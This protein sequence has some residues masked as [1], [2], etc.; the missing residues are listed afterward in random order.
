MKIFITLLFIV[1][2]ALCN[3]KAYELKLYEKVLGSIFIDNNKINIYTSDN[4]K[5]T[6]KKSKKFEIVDNCKSAIILVG[7]EF[8]KECINKP[9]FATSYNEYKTQENVIGAFYWRKGRPQLKL[10]LNNLNKFK[11]HLPEEL[12]KFAQ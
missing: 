4:M 8:G 12:R 11:L 2:N 10:K 1:T 7:K 9:L 3:N 6:L 5:S